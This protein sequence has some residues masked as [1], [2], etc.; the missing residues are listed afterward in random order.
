MHFWEKSTLAA[1][2][3]SDKLGLVFLMNFTALWFCLR[4][5][6]MK[7][8]NVLSSSGSVQ[9]QFKNGSL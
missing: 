6:D 1:E 7:R 5:G 3:P 4:W 2:V 9:F 8:T